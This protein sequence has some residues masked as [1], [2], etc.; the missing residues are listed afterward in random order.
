[1]VT[2]IVDH[3][4]DAQGPV[5]ARLLDLVETGSTDPPN[6]ADRRR[7]RNL[8]PRS[9]GL[10]PPLSC[11]GVGKHSGPL[12]T[13]PKPPIALAGYGAPDV[14]P[15]EQDIY[16]WL[17]ALSLTVAPRHS[18]NGTKGSPA[19]NHLAAAQ[20]IARRSFL[21]CAGA[22]AGCCPPRVRE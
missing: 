2:G 15:S 18:L 7:T 14:L 3:T 4:R 22:L 19:T 8:V 5:H 17:Q 16:P 12:H 13:P 11:T 20:V 1:M 10:W 21:I 6:P 9:F